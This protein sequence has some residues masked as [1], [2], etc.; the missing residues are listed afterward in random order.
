MVYHGTTLFTPFHSPLLPPRQ[1]L[2]IPLLSFIRF[3]FS[4][5]FCKIKGVLSITIYTSV[6]VNILKRSAE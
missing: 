1:R 6:G 5:F 4:L 3:L 2:T